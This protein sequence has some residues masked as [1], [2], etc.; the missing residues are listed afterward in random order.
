MTGD[1]PP[2]LWRT[3]VP[4]FL[5]ALDRISQILDK[6]EAL[7]D[8]AAA[9]DQPPAEGMLPAGQQIATAMPVIAHGV[10]FRRSE[11]LA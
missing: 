2:A 6:T 4:V 8:P 11:R 9:L 10:G 1:A 3:T 5:S 7:P